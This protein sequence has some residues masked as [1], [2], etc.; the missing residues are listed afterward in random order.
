[1]SAL[2]A[3]NSYRPISRP[4][5]SHLQLV[6]PDSIALPETGYFR[7]TLNIPGIR[8]PEQTFEL[9]KK[10]N[11]IQL[12]NQPE[13]H[14]PLV[15]IEFTVN[16]QNGIPSV[17]SAS[18]ALTD[19]ALRAEL[20]YT[21]YLLALH[22]AQECSF[23]FGKSSLKLHFPPLPEDEVKN[24]KG[25]AAICRKLLFVE[26]CFTLPGQSFFT[27]PE[28][29][30]DQSEVRAI[31]FAFRACSEGEF[32]VRAGSFGIVLNSLNTIDLQSPPF[33]E[34]GPFEMLLD[35]KS[36]GPVEVFGQR[37]PLGP[38]MI[39]IAHAVLGNS[40]VI[41]QLRQKQGVSA[42]LRLVVVDNQI[43]YR[44]PKLISRLSKPPRSQLNFFRKRLAAEEPSEIALLLD[45]PLEEELTLE[46]ATKAAGNWLF[47]GPLPNYF[48]PGQAQSRDSQTW[49][50][51][52]WLM[53][54]A[55]KTGVE[56]VGEMLIHKRTGEI[57]SHPI[58]EELLTRLLERTP[59]PQLPDPE[60]VK[61]SK[62]R[63]LPGDQAKLS[64]LLTLNREGE[65]DD[66]GRCDLNKM[67]RQT[68]LGLLYKSEA[69][70][71]AVQRG[72]REPLR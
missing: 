65:L 50:I 48:V 12:R 16:P 64:Y 66:K 68:N 52:I 5:S 72:L 28:G 36:Q 7:A 47:H 44:F 30:L 49:L 51:P 15:S 22:N 62:L 25:R 17:A 59:V 13:H 40:E 29:T 58:I 53:D 11:R 27:L 45:L 67:M 9:Q 41:E 35:E 2:L 24:F 37:L 57:L 18:I 31:E 20:Y 34:P 4:R 42:T 56:Q 61:I 1:M 3:E 19:K 55:K 39:Q 54:E 69:L 10:G 60:V 33:S 23:E 46:D 32:S 26:Q 43:H 63:L 71:V 70:K 14:H 6:L 38:M 8:V 21:R